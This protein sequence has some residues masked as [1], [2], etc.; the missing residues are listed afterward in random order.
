MQ[1]L[2][3]LGTGSRP[4]PWPKGASLLVA[5]GWPC[6]VDI[7][8]RQLWSSA[9]GRIVR[10]WRGRPCCPGDGARVQGVTAWERDVAGELAQPRRR[11]MP[12]SPVT[13]DPALFI[14]AERAD[15]RC[16]GKTPSERTGRGAEKFREVM[17]AWWNGWRP[18]PMQHPTDSVASSSDRTARSLTG[19][20]ARSGSPVSGADFVYIYIYIYIY[21]YTHTHTHTHTCI[22]IFYKRV[23]YNQVLLYILY[24]V[25]LGYKGLAYKGHALIREHSLR[26]RQSFN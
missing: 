10:K 9:S 24:T 18:D 19:D 14:D 8:S 6:A 25:E 11:P 17:R 5:Q 13:Y 7:S 4:G 21:I 3:G 2:R 20:V 26:S 16:V 1:S 15:G 23:P 22:Y 12:A